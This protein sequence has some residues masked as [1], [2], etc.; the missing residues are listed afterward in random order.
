M[1]TWLESGPGHSTFQPDPF[2]YKY[3]PLSSQIII[4][5]YPPV[6]MEPTEC[7]ETTAFNIQKPGLYPE[8][9]I[10][11][12]QHGEILKTMEKSCKAEQATDDNI[13]HVHCM[14]DP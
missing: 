6:K 13:A 12:L 9:N 3:S 2:P 5:T 14:P 11:Y 10:P 4:H 8:E 7:S 1:I